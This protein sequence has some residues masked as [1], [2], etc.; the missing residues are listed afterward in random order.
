MIETVKCSDYEGF[1]ARGKKG[2]VQLCCA[3]ADGA[4]GLSPVCVGVKDF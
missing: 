1:C 4:T 2:F 3:C